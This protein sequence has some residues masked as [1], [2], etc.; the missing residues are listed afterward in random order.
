VEPPHK[1]FSD[2]VSRLQGL[3]YL[4][5][6]EAFIRERGGQLQRHD[7]FL[8]TVPE[9]LQATADEYG[10]NFS[11]PFIRGALIQ[12]EREHG[13]LGAGGIS[14]GRI[15]AAVERVL[16]SPEAKRN[17]YGWEWAYVTKGLGTIQTETLH[18]WSPVRG[19]FWGTVVN[20]A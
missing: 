3:G 20:R 9:A 6:T 16:F 11:N 14:E 4:P 17:D 1:D 18:L 10:W 7:A 2:V 8:F 5:L 19:Y 13:I 12:F 15:H